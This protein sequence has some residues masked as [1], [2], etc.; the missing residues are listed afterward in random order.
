MSKKVR[1]PSTTGRLYMVKNMRQGLQ[2]PPGALAQ[3]TLGT[4]VHATFEE[5]EKRPVK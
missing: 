3:A 5:R 2:V 4:E 1:T